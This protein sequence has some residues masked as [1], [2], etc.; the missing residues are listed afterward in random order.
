MTTKTKEIIGPVSNGA[1]RTIE[2]GRP[3]RILVTVQGL[4]PIL[5]RAWNIEAVKAKSDSVKGGIAKKTDDLES[6]VYRLPN[7]NIGLMGDSLRA[8]LAAAGRYKQDPRSPRKSASDLIKAGLIPLTP[9]ADTG[10]KDWDTVARHRV[11]IQRASI[12]RSRPSLNIGWKATFDML[13]NSPQYLTPTFIQELLKDAGTICG[14]GD[15]RPT[16][17][18][19]AVSRFEALAF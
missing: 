4:A 13:V 11:V 16:Y 18:R 2:E 9:L 15:Y 8:C 1:V 19:F 17:G 3:Y 14:L 10:V 12:T 7:G 6:Y 5:L